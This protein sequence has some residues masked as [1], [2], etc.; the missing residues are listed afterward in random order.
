MGVYMR[1]F[2]A[3]VLASTIST[4]AI[5]Q[6]VSGP[7]ALTPGKPAG[8]HQAQMAL[9]NN[10]LYLALGITAIGAGI[11]VAASNSHS[12]GLGSSSVVSVTTTTAP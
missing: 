3:V 5:A 1:R 2:V 12:A 6:T 9:F 10:P 8:V 7:T 11:A 4:T